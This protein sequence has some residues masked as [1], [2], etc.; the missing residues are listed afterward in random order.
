MI[1]NKT[2]NYS[3]GRGKQAIYLTQI[4][5]YGYNSASTF[6]RHSFADKIL[7]FFP[8]QPNVLT[9]GIHFKHRTLPLQILNNIE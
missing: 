1:S 8:N 4:I 2:S 9:A 6:S 7:A 5:I 3:S